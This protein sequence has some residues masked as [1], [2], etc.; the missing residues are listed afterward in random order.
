MKLVQRNYASL[1]V[2]VVSCTD[3]FK[4]SV[5][6]TLFSRSMKIPP[7]LYCSSRDMPFSFP[8]TMQARARASLVGPSAWVTMT[9]TKSVST[10]F[11]V[12][13]SKIP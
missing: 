2:S 7:A 11:P 4:L 9:D 5:T 10:G 8:N 12:E 3:S 13:G 6:V 1:N